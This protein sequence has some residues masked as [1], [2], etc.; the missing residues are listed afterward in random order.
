M[1]KFL[2]R[3][4]VYMSVIAAITLAVN[5]LYI[6]ID[7]KYRSPNIPDGNIQICN[8]GSSHGQCGFNYEDFKGK[9]ICSNFALSSQSLLYDYRILQH[10]Q[11]KIQPGATVF[12][13]ASYF[14]FFGVPETEGKDFLSK[15][16]RYYKF[17]PPELILQYDRK[18][19]MYVNYLP[20]ISP[21]ELKVLVKHLFGLNKENE[22]I[23]GIFN[24]YGAGGNTV[25]NSR[26]AA[27]DASKAY[28]RH[29]S[30]SIDEN[31]R[32]LRRQE[33]FEAIYGMIDL[34]RQ[35]GAKP[36][37][38]TVPYLREYTDL[39]RKN[40]PE[41]FSD[42]YAVI[43]EIRHNTGIEY[44]DYAFD[45]RFCTDYGLF[46]NSD[47]MNSEGARKFTNTLLHEVLGIDPD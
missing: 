33:S 46:S 11:D 4:A 47:H 26:D 42:F 27:W 41:F 5:V 3:I 7:P 21:S 30:N 8:F 18:T 13:V 29:F 15:N 12:I 36:I 28:G 40:D 45:E 38:V 39:V 44:Y 16:K 14:S 35:I 2:T 32:R 37:L 24:V 43:E 19:D 31:G 1:R 10:Y 9:Y 34:C 25:T 6:C 22:I 17:L 23:E 20:C